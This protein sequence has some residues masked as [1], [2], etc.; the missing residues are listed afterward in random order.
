MPENAAPLFSTKFCPPPVRPPLVLRPRLH[1]R[2][3][4]GLERKLT[5]VSAPAGYGKTT[6]LAEWA[7]TI[8][9]PV[10]WLALDADDNDPGRFSLCVWSALDGRLDLPGWPAAADLAELPP[11]AAMLRLVY[12]LESSPTPLAL[13]LDDYHLLQSPELHRATAALV[14]HLPP[15]V[16]LYIATRKDPPIPLARL[17]SLGELVEVRQEHLRFTPDESASF[18]REKMGLRLSP[19]DLAALARQTEGWAAGLQLAALSLL[20]HPDPGPFIQSIGGG[21]RFILDYLVEEV[22]ETQPPEIQSFLLRTSLLRRLSAPLCEAVVGGPHAGE[23]LAYLERANLFLTALDASRTWFRYHHLFAELLQRRLKETTPG[24]QLNDLHRRAAAWYEAAGEPVEAIHHAL[25]AHAWPEAARLMEAWGTDCFKTG[26]LGTYLPMLRSLPPDELNRHP[27]LLQ[28]M[29]WGLAL[30]NDLDQAEYYLNLAEAAQ[31]GHSNFLGETLSGLA[32]TAC[33]RFDIER[34][35][36]LGRRALEALDPDNEWMRSVVWMVLALAHWFAGDPEASEGAM[37]AAAPAARRSGGQRV[38]KMAL[39]YQGKCKALG[40]D[41]LAAEAL[42]RSAIGSDPQPQLAPGNEVPA[43]DLA[44]L[45]YEWDDLEAAGRYLDLGFAANEASRNRLTR[46]AGLRILAR[47]RMAQG[48]GEEAWA[49]AQE[50]VRISDEIGMAPFFQDLNAACCVEL[51][52][53]QQD[54]ERAEAWAGRISGA[55]G[56]EAFHPLPRLAVARLHLARRRPELA[57]RLL[58]ELEPETRGP[59]RRF[60]AFRLR[61]LQALALRQ[62]PSLRAGPWREAEPLP[63]ADLQ[64][65]LQQKLARSFIDLGAPAANLLRSMSP[66]EPALRKRLADLVRRCEADAAG[67][68]ASTPVETP[69]T[70]EAPLPPLAEELSAR[71]LDVL[72]RLGAGESTAGIAAALF[73]AESTVRT[74]IKNIFV[75]LNVHSRLQA[76]EQARR[77]G[78]V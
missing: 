70:A 35:L 48:R 46:T 23:T 21:N 59:T 37:Q 56:L 76:V 63:V 40:M 42:A 28:D 29:G 71:E 60:A 24:E 4:Q 19:E 38:L 25:A 17:R 78:L 45:Y 11:R 57:L 7:A 53:A 8:P 68:P 33:Y 50:A 5:L 52:L 6:L 64:T 65:A 34:T 27:Q 66:A 75:K 1:Q 14:E 26:A 30:T 74:H 32:Y 77:R 15:Q 49:A 31:P 20:E 2:L 12:S 36:V 62:K 44:A 54:I 39:A 51:S 13:V 43:F 18:L 69:V 10:A 61:L 67:T 73:V 55:Q 41:F 22:L 3:D 47:L 58:T 72:R 9:L 16:H